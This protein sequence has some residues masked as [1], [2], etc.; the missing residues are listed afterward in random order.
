[1]NEV[2]R[3]KATWINLRN[4]VNTKKETR[5]DKDDYFYKD[6]K[7]AKLSI[8]LLGICKITVSYFKNIAMI[9]I[10]VLRAM[11]SDTGRLLSER[12]KEYSS[13]IP[14]IWVAVEQV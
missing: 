14:T 7:Q 8:I 5:V 11:F 6:Q 4:V 1:M 13:V 2:L 10:W 9:K 12:R 3:H